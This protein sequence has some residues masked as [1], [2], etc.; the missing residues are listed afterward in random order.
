MGVCFNNN[1]YNCEKDLMEKR[2]DM[3][4]DGSACHEKLASVVFEHCPK[5]SEREPGG[6]NGFNMR[7]SQVLVNACEE[8]QLL[9]K[10]ADELASILSAECVASA[11]AAAAQQKA[12]T[13]LVV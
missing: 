2:L 1:L 6:W 9:A 11:A 5:R 13:T 12:T 8:Q 3:S 7:Y 4:A 10:N